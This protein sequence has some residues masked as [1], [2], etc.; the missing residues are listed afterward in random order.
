MIKVK[1][2]LEEAVA[3]YSLYFQYGGPNIPD[4]VIDYLSGMYQNRAKMLGICKDDNFR[5]KAGIKMQLRCIQHVVT[6][7]DRGMSNAGKLFYETYKLYREDRK[8]FE[9][10]AESFFE[11][12][13]I[14]KNGENLMT[15]P[16]TVVKLLG[17]YPDGLTI[18][19]ITQIMIDQNLYNF[20][21]EDPKNVV[22]RAVRRHCEGV[23]LSDGASEKYF[24]I[25]KRKN[26]K[27][28]Y[29]L[30]FENS[31][32]DISEGGNSR[33]SGEN[34]QKYIWEK[35]LSILPEFTFPKEQIQKII[36]TTEAGSSR[37]MRMEAQNQTVRKLLTDFCFCI[38]DYQRSYS[39]KAEQI[40]E[41]LD[42]LY[43]IVHG[44][45]LDTHHFLGALTMTKNK[46]KTYSMDLVDGQQRITTI[47]IL[48][49]VIL[50]EYKSDRFF[51]KADIKANKRAE[52]LYRT[53]VYLDDDGEVIDS[54]LVLGKFNEEFFEEYVIKGHET[55]EEEKAAI[56]KKYRDRREFN[57][58]QPIADAYMQIKKSIEERL[59]SCKNDYDAYEYLKALHIAIYDYFEV[60][61]MIVE[62]EADAFLIFET[63]N[64]RGLAL[65][66]VDLIKNKLFQIFATRPNEFEDLKADWESICRNVDKKDDLKKFILHYWRSKIDY[67]AQQSLYK[68]CRDYLSESSFE[69]A[70]QI[71]KDLKE[72]SVYYNG[73]CNPKGNY[74]WKNAELKELLE[75]MNKLRY[76]L[77]RPILLSGWR[78]YQGDEG[79]LVIISRLCLNFMIRYISVLNNKP[80]TIEKELSKWARD[81]EFSIEMLS[82]NFKEKAPDSEFEEKLQT[83]SMPHTSNLAHYLLCVYEA[84]GFGRK[85]IWTSPGRG[86]NTVE[87]VL[88]QTVKPG[89]DGGDYWIQQFG[90]VEQCDLFSSKLGNYAFLTKKAQGKASNKDFEK[91]K[92]VYDEETDMLLT[93]ELC[94][95]NDWNSSA[96]AKRQKRMTE[97]WIKYISFD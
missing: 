34:K 91:K 92:K 97:I 14:E 69:T 46:T 13:N 23:E 28:I 87:H 38:P 25:E 89:K 22:Q 43:N 71:L 41:F 48:L 10:I 11:K 45:S 77:V 33:E 55:S 2:Q 65:S 63:L 64:D 88:P 31:A 54:R 80:T 5:N 74:P 76:D 70:K 52:G 67:T 56:I 95:F 90:S 15:I 20:G 24:S 19:E 26:S 36:S 1:W 44:D 78:K 7:K 40:N 42:D 4:D 50:E 93:K 57:E 12:Y 16:E 3:L 21:T 6:G 96:I 73:F 81:P 39:W 8:K 53:L 60:V 27:D 37:S 83:I 86:E 61:T 49:Y 82:K 59:N 66:A 85:E 32:I 79:K 47:F 75:N 62:D 29:K 51:L 58:N 84:E 17:E 9:E 35:K 18:N 94:S 68:T 72:E 30:L